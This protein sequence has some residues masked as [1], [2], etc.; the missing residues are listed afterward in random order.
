MKGHTEAKSRQ[1]TGSNCCGEGEVPA[2]E[3]TPSCEATFYDEASRGNTKF[4]D[5]GP[6][7][8]GLGKMEEE[9]TSGTR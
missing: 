2:I 4:D 9:H 5:N 6:N 3:K 8:T 7:V 1:V